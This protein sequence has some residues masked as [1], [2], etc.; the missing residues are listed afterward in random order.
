MAIA[1]KSIPVLTGKAAERFVSMADANKGNTT[2]IVPKE[3]HAAI[4]RMKERSNNFT[5][6]YPNK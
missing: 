4:K 2:T 5:I 1:I 6:K 3:M